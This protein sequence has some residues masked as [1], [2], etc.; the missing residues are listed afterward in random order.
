MEAPR[1]KRLDELDN[2]APASVSYA[3]YFV[4]CIMLV[5]PHSHAYRLIRNFGVM[6]HFVH[7]LV[8]SRSGVYAFNT[9]EPT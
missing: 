1:T 4:G 5:L 9:S 3:H 6:R 7:C 8:S 2:A